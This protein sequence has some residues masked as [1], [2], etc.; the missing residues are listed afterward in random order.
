VALPHA[1]TLTS[2]GLARTTRGYGVGE[3]HITL[4]PD[5]MWL[6][7][8]EEDQAAR[9]AE[10]ELT[11]YGL[12]G[13]RGLD[14]E[15]LDSLAVLVR[16]KVE[17]YAW[18]H[19][20]DTLR[21]VLSAA[22]GREALHAVRVGEQITLRQIKSNELVDALLA[23][24]P[25]TAPLRF[26][27]ISLPLSEVRAALNRPAEGSYPR[28]AGTPNAAPDIRL[29]QRLMNMPVSGTGQL[30]AAVRDELGRRRR[31]QHPI[32]VVDT[33]QGRLQNVTTGKPGGESWVVVAP[34]G[35]AALADRLHTMH[36]ELL[37]DS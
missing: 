9:A 5:A 2:D 24:L 8:E 36:K 33:N 11:R 16:P 28:N 15:L 19:A 10:Q 18:F 31:V 7:S 12:I 3:P 35:R 13:P 30:F 26:Q 29:L 6:D 23:E 22:I 1:L 14:V 34:A 20:G 21:A 17:F 27:S 25:D 32:R 4:A 37:A